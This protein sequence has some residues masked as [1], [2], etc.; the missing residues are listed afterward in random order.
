MKKA[1]VMLSGGLDS[2][3]IVKT[4]QRQEYEII[5]LYFKLPF[6]KDNEKEIKEYCKKHKVRL[7]VF[8]YTKGKLLN[9]YLEIIKKPRHGRGTGINPC[10]DCRIFMLNK[11]REYADKHNVDI[12]ATGEVLGQRPMSQHKKG[13]ELVEADSK[14]KGRL[15]RPLIDLGIQGRRRDKQMKMAEKFKIDYP[16]PAGGCLLCESGLKKRFN[17]LI[18][19]GLNSEEIKLSNVG[20][21]FVI[22]NCWIVLGRNEKENKIIEKLKTGKVILPKKIGPTAIILD[23]C[24]ESTKEKVK[25][26]IEAYSKNGNKKKFERYLI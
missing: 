10:I 3:L 21:H 8:D 5:A 19:R 15:I 12:I 9:E 4:M 20:R 7:K 14:L 13:L 25:K 16:T 26:L 24:K 23:K 1:I 2:R 6:S 22:N 17:F 11:A 18:K